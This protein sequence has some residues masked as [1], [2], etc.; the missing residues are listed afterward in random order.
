MSG[1]FYSALIAIYFFETVLATCPNDCK[2]ADG[3]KRGVCRG[4]NW[5][6]DCHDGWISGDCSERTCAYGPAWFDEAIGVDDAHN[7]AEC[8]NMGICDRLTGLCTCREGFSGIA[9]ERMNCPVDA[10]GLTCA[11]HGRCMSMRE[12][13]EHQDDYK[14][15]YSVSY[16]AWDADRIYGCVCDEGF[17]GYDCSLFMC[18]GGDDPQSPLQ[19]LDEIQ[20]IDCICPGTCS[21]SFR[22]SFRSDFTVDIPYSAS[23]NDIKNA[24]DSLHRLDGVLVTLSGG[25]SVCDNDGA[26]AKIQFAQ[27]PGNLPALIVH[28]SL[29]ASGGTP[30]ITVRSGGATSTYAGANSQNGNRENHEC[31]LRGTCDRT[32]GICTCDEGFTSSNGGGGTGGVAL[33]NGTR[34]DCGV[35]RWDITP[36]CPIDASNV[37]CSGHGI[38]L[39]STHASGSETY[40]CQCLSGFTGHNCALLDCPTGTA[41]FDEATSSTVAHQSA[42]CSNGGL[43]DYEK[44]TCTCAP[45]LGGSACSTILCPGASQDTGEESGGGGGAPAPAPGGEG[46]ENAV[47]SGKGTCKTISAVALLAKNEFGTSLGYTYGAS[48]GIDTWD[49]DS[50]VG[51]QCDQR[52]YHGPFLGDATDHYGYDCSQIQCPYGDDPASEGQHHETQTIFCQADGGTFTLSFYGYTTSAIAHNANAATVEAALEIL[53]SIHVLYGVG[54]EVSIQNSGTTVCSDAGAFTDITFKQNLGDVPML[55]LTG[56]SLTRAGGSVLTKMIEKQKG[57]YENEECSLRG[58]CYPLTG[59]CSCFKY[60]ASSDGSGGGGSR[61]DCGHRNVHQLINYYPVPV[62]G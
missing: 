32:T 16:N 51:C 24:L 9:C 61:A 34:G 40:Q 3:V 62:G 29:S 22:L 12:Y 31:N 13:A 25:T 59:L 53:S 46:G 44:G 15:F 39:N 18:P 36:N 47:C 37:I 7:S 42:L 21:G 5:T 26:A 20:Y 19:L 38:C 28:S 1:L 4:P 17:T 8:S 54:V 56:S 35:A 50:M 6:C 2:S 23:A 55:V 43:C 58:K 45:H 41:W 60:Y 48:G 10:N 14:S 11:G 30:T 49:K 33:A 52:S 57:T 27:N